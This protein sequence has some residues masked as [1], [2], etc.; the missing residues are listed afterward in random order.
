MELHSEIGVKSTN[1]EGLYIL[2]SK[3]WSS[4]LE[5]L[6]CTPTDMIILHFQEV[7]FHN[8]KIVDE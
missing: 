1:E 8:V 5:H 3:R 7:W 2:E 4:C 6:K